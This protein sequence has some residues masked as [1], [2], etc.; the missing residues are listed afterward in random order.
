MKCILRSDRTVPTIKYICILSEFEISCCHFVTSSPSS[1]YIIS[2]YFLRKLET[3]WECKMLMNAAACKI[4][5]THCE[6]SILDT[7][8]EFWGSKGENFNFW[9]SD[10]RIFF[11]FF[12]F[13][14]SWILVVWPGNHSKRHRRFLEMERDDCVNFRSA[15]GWLMAL[16]SNLPTLLAE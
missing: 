10:H 6:F 16:Q 12:D 5:F 1:C 8:S 13:F 4:Q 2:W 7:L 14:F 15:R 3:Y 9:K 11:S